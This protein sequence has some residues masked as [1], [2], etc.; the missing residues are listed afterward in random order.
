MLFFLR[1]TAPG[2]LQN[3]VHIGLDGQQLPRLVAGLAQLCVGRLFLRQQRGVLGLQVLHLWQLLD[4]QLVKGPLRRLMEQDV[5]LVL[6][7]EL[8]GVPGLAVG[9]VGIA[10]PGIVDNVGPQHGDLRHALLRRLDFLG[11]LAAPRRG[12]FRFFRQHCVIHQAVLVEIAQGLC[13]LFQVEFAGPPRI[14]G[15]LASAELGLNVHQQIDLRDSRSRGGSPGRDMLALPSERGTQVGFPIAVPQG[16]QADN[17][18]PAGCPERNILTSPFGGKAR[19]LQQLQKGLQVLRPALHG[20]VNGLPQQLPVGGLGLGAQPLV[21][22]LALGFWVLHNGQAVFNAQ[23]IT[24]PPHGASAAPKVAELAGAVQRGGVPNDVIMDV[25]T[26]YVG[27]DDKGMI[28]LGKASGKLHADAVGLLRR[29]LSRHK[30]LP[31]MVGDHIVRAPPP[32]GPGEVLLLAEQ[33]LR[34]RDRAV[35]AMGRNEPALVGLVRVLNIVQNI[36]DGGAHA[37]ALAGVQGHDAGGCQ[38]KSS[39][40]GA[41]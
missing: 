17:I 34:V 21:V 10:G 7:T 5:G 24:Q 28:V 9:G 6:R 32:A 4:V 26:I 15:T 36:A 40:P 1:D 14:T 2:V 30:R 31:D 16:F 29:D 33:K 8:R 39:F 23:G 20:P 13:H 19:L 41:Y 22:G 38:K 37:P 27:A 35:A 12:R 3:A 18:F 11:Q 25:R